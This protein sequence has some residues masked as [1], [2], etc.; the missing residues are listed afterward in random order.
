MQ[1]KENR[2]PLEQIAAELD[3]DYVLDGSVR[4]AKGDDGSRVRITP[5]LVRT[6][7]DSQM[8]AESYDRVLADVFDMQSE[9][10]AEVVSQL[11]ITLLEPERADLEARPTDNLEAYQAFL[12]GAHIQNSSDFTEPTRR[13]AVEDLETA[14]ELDPEFALAWAALSH[15]HGF[16]YRLGYDLTD[17][18]AQVARK[19]YDRALELDPDSPEVL[20]ELGYYHYYIEQDHEAALERFQAAERARPD[21]AE[22]KSA[23]AFVWRRQGRFAEGIERLEE[24]FA[25]SPR[26]AQIPALI[27]EFAQ[28]TREYEKSVE[29]LDKSIALAPDE[30]WPYVQKVQTLWLSR[31]DLDEARRILESI[32]DSASET[33]VLFLGWT[34]LS[35]MERDFDRTLAVQEEAASEWY[36]HQ[37]MTIPKSLVIAEAL[38]YKGDLEGAHSEYQAALEAV[39]AALIDRPEDYRLH[40]SRGVALAGLGR[41]DE[42]IAAG[43]RAIELMP[44]EKDLYIGGQFIHDMALIYAMLGEAEEALEQ[45]DRLLSIPAKFSVMMLKKDPRWDSLRDHPR[46]QDL[47]DKYS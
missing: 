5:Q 4:W 17:A 21:D 33:L 26:N 32:P 47:I 40:S 37:T 2:P 15:A 38:G 16:Y 30:Y 46:Y 34:D 18:R 7:D 22:I 9:I 19:A 24:A 42:A 8:W 44:I 14:V 45:L 1:Y 6:A 28:M 23:I 3:V 41:R 36:T 25:L 29:Y 11:G 13:R 27:G 20:Y 39:E 35:R 10:A 12:R 31:E 43:Q